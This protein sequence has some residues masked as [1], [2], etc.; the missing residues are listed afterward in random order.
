MTTTSTLLVGAACGIV[1]GRFVADVAF[2]LAKLARRIRA[3]RRAAR[4]KASR[5][6]TSPFERAWSE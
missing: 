5:E 3:V 6:T 2:D 1:I 4:E